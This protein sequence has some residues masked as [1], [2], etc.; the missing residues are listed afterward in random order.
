MKRTATG[1]TFALVALPVSASGDPSVIYSGLGLLLGWI[2]LVFYALG[3]AKT[4]LQKA[5]SAASTII[6]MGV[7]WHLASLPYR[8][9]HVVVNYGSW[10]A[11]GVAALV[12]WQATRWRNDEE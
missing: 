5:V 4:S 12:I 10:A 9:N 1:A 8:D 7:T 11:L 6:G 3:R 2:L